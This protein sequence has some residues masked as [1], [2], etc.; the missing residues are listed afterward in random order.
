MA[1]AE[2]DL[3]GPVREPER[4]AA[5]TDAARG[6]QR[7]RRVGEKVR[8]MNA[9]LGLGSA[10]PV[11]V[12]G[13]HPFRQLLAGIL[14]TLVA[15]GAAVAT[16]HHVSTDSSFPGVLTASK[17]LDLNFPVTGRLVE[18]SVR[19]GDRVH[20][21][22]VLAREDQSVAQANLA[23]ASATVVADQAMVDSTLAPQVSDALVQ[24]L[25]LQVQQARVVA[26]NAAR[27]SSDAAGV[28]AASVSEAQSTVT[29][30]QASV[31]GDRSR[32]QAACPQGADAPGFLSQTGSSSP[33]PDNASLPPLG[34]QL[35][36][37]MNCQ[38]LQA[39]LDKDAAGVV[40]AT[41]NLSHTKAMAQ[42]MRD[43]AAAA[44]SSSNASLALAQQQLPVQLAAQT[45]AQIAQ[46]RANLAQAQAQVAQAQEVLL[47]TT[48]S[49]PVDGV[50]ANLTGGPGE[51][52]SAAGVHDFGGPT[53]VSATAPG[54]SLFPSQPAAQTGQQSASYSPLVS[55][56]ATS[57]PL[58]VTSDV[59]EA[60][61]G[62]FHA[63]DHARVSIPALDRSMSVVVDHIIA[64]P[65]Q[66]SGGVTY[67]VSL[68]GADWPQGA[69]PGMSVSVA[70]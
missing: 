60:S 11:E 58:D 43:V 48:I 40:A 55:L 18:I 24:Q 56:Y 7:P 3:N 41:A 5:V 15:V 57:G 29:S 33:S 62:R 61:I 20:A 32:F 53:D 17:R 14:I 35:Q 69:L 6:R 12:R 4:A 23:A 37:F 67:E 52:V 45:P 36:A 1:I 34:A 38:S 42:Q 59:P 2:H 46:A 63:G 49:A 31:A 44:A 70:L 54:F 13:R 65:A 10:G 8:G 47:E 30:S 64:L 9:A 27:A 25:A 21:G 68:R 16:I 28:A 51:L 22:Q 50:V 66:G 26:S 39:Q 19:P